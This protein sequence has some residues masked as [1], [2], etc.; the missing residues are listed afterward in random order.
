MSLQPPHTDGPNNDSE[1]LS[2][3]SLKIGLPDD[4]LEEALSPINDLW[5][6][7][8]YFKWESKAYHRL[9]SLRLERVASCSISEVEL[10]NVLG[11]S[12]KLRFVDIDLIIIRT[13][14]SPDL[15]PT[16]LP[17]LELIV[18]NTSLLGLIRPGSN[19]LT[20]TILDSNSGLFHDASVRGFF[21]CANL[22]TFCSMRTLCTTSAI[23]HLLSIAPRLRGLA[24]SHTTL[25]GTLPDM[26]PHTLDTLYLLNECVLE[27]TLLQEMIER[28]GIKR[29]VFQH[30]SYHSS[31]E[32]RVPYYQLKENLPALSLRSV[33]LEFAPK[34]PDWGPPMEL[35]LGPPA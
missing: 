20:V 35:L 2:R 11:S 32:E 22:V 8:A 14:E 17:D 28:W 1:D 4:Q 10:M 34:V 23:C 25:D 19:E 31:G 7:G 33:Q 16:H 24:I 9:V 6:R 29:V 3:H 26:T 5:L 15:L 21:S 13:V 27:Q 30:A 12:P 18:G